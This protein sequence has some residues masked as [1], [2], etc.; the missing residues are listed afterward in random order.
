VFGDAGFGKT[1]LLRTLLV[2]LA[3]TY[4]PAAF[5]A[6][7]LD[8]GGRTMR[9]LAA[10]PH[11]GSVIYADEEAFEERL[12][13]LFDKLSRMTE[14][15]QQRISDGDVSTIYEYNARYPD[16][17]L[18][19]VLLMIDNYAELQENYTNLVETTLLPLLRRSLAMGITCVVACNAPNNIAS[20][21]YSLFSERLTFK[22]TNFD[23]YL[24]IV[25][26]GA[27]EIDDIPGLGYIRRGRQPLLF[28]AAQPVGI[29]DD[30]G[31]DILLAAEEMRLMA[32]TMHQHIAESGLSYTPPDPIGILPRYVALEDMMKLVPVASPR[33]EGIVGQNA[34]LNAAAFNLK[35]QGA[36]FVVAGPPLS[37]KTTVLYNWVLS[38]TARYSPEQ[39]KLVLIDM[40]RKFFEYGG[41][42]KL[43]ELP[44]VVT[45]VSEVEQVK[46]LIERLKREGELLATQ[47]DTRH[48]VF[49]LIDNFDEFSDEISRDRSANTVGDLAGLARRYGRSGLHFIISGTFDSNRNDLQRRIQA[50]NLGIGLRTEQAISALNVLRTPAAVRNSELPPGRGYIVRSGQPTMIQVALPVAEHSTAQAA[51][52]NEE[53]R[54]LLALDN[55][56]EQICAR[57]P[58][59]RAT[60]CEA[61]EMSVAKSNGST[62]Q[63]PRVKRMVAVL[64]AVMR[65][66]LDQLQE[67]NGQEELLT[68]TLMQQ[69]D[70]SNWHD[71]AVLWQHL[72]HIWVAEYMKQESSSVEEAETTFADWDPG[73]KLMNLEMWLGIDV[74]H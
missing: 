53:E 72:K 31:R 37:G 60:W 15:R 19:T 47:L 36:H 35:R 26:R 44:H 11:V 45:T 69:M 57:Y 16:Q 34:E 29:F 22:Q 10:L 40:Q 24:D 13:R 5:Q 65:K 54:L 61:P 14:E 43:D 63:S 49:V 59:Q 38:L 23:R 39:V 74:S 42:H 48:E 18:P 68:S 3:A 46:T 67:H 66:E 17:A 55:W 12:Q 73:S 52:E 4:S 6:Y 21:V 50:S 8:L 25:G 32:N 1:M 7:I 20:K 28:Q 64:Q 33:I 62:T 56:V 27:I 9:S 2:S 58:G 41:Q 30:D 71:E 70:F 51:A